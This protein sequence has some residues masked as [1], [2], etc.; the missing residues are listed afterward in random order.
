VAATVLVV[1][2]VAARAGVTTPAIPAIF[3]VVIAG[4]AT[5]FIS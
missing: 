4:K 5:A 3:I 1:V 2:F